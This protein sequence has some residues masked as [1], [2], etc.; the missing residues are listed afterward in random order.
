[1]ALAADVNQYLLPAP[2]LQMQPASCCDLMGEG[3]RTLVSGSRTC[4]D[5][6]M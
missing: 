5:T 3:R 6:L 2:E 1:L 4:T